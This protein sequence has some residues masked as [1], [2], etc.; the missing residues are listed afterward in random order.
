MIEI[1]SKDP[2]DYIEVALAVEIL[3][4]HNKSCLDNE[5]CDNAKQSQFI[6]YCLKSALKLSKNNP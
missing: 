1:V 2:K 5:L 6:Q 4:Y 3:S